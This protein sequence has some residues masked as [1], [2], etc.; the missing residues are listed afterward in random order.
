MLVTL[1]VAQT[2]TQPTAPPTSPSASTTTLPITQ[3]R[4]TVVFLQLRCRDGDQEYDARGTGFFVGYQDTRLGKG[5]EFNYLVTNRHVALCWNGPGHPMQVE[6]IQMSMNRREGDTGLS[7]E[8]GFLSAHGNVAWILPEDDSVDLAVLP[9]APDPMRFDFLVFPFE[10]LATK[11]FLHQNGVVEGEPVIFAGFFYQ[12][13]GTRRIEPIV[14]QGIIAMMPDEKFPLGGIQENLYLADAHVFQGN[15]GSPVFINLAGFRSNGTI[16]TGTDYRLI[17]VINGEVYED[18]NFNLQLV[19]TIR[20]TGQANSGISTI[21]PAD[22]LIKLLNDP[23]VQK[24]R[25]DAVKALVSP[26]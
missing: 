17:G 8:Q 7:V 23:R 14:R 3:I 18:E 22:E 2:P 25:D 6:N 26:K 10:L 4:K 24:V 19:T 12:F 11:D 20:G 15:S 21:V 13:P 1:S 5:R 9:L 16:T